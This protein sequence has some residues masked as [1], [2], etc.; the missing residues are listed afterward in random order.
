MYSLKNISKPIVFVPMAA[1][2]F[3]HGH[4]NILLKAKKYG[5]IVV[6]LM[7]DKGI[8]KYKKKYP[9]IKFKNRKKVL[10][11]IKCIE[12][13][14]PIDGLE[15]L[16][17]AKFYKFDYFIHGND[18]K[19]NIQSDVRK[20]LIILMKKWRGKVVDLPYTKNISSSI[21]RKKIKK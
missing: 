11:Q 15:Y 3:H 7:T 2:V 14:I 10:E 8:K 13:I 12:R 6:G 9:L 17:F 20:K 16:K 18:W 1:D 5:N 4:V 21:I 19:K